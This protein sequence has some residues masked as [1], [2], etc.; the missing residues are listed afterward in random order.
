MMSHM[1]KGK[2]ATPEDTQGTTKRHVLAHLYCG[3]SSC[4]TVYQ[5][6]SG[7]VIIQGYAVPEERLDITLAEGEL[8]VEVPLTLLIEAIRR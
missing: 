4:P 6:S 8:L 3:T 1:D 7:M 2:A 5:G